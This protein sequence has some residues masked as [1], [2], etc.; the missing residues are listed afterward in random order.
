MQF[1]LLVQR[2][3]EEVVEEQV[4]LQEAEVVQVVLY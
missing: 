3:V 2:V 4:Q 1:G